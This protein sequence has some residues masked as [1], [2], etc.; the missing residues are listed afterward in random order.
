MVRLVGLGLTKGR[1]GR[2]STGKHAASGEYSPYDDWEIQ[3]VG[4]IQQNL[5]VGL[6]TQVLQPLCE[7]F[8][9]HFGLLNAEIATG[10]CRIKKQWALSSFRVTRGK[11]V[12]WDIDRGKLQIYGE[13]GINHASSSGNIGFLHRDSVK[14]EQSS[15]LVSA[16][17]DPAT[18]GPEHCITWRDVQYDAYN[19]AHHTHVVPQRTL[20]M[21]WSSAPSTP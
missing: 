3:L 14:R 17:I 6:E 20:G 15:G 2:R 4:R 18:V 21:T 19:I 13:G 12:G 1:G 16:K 11:H 10:V 8:N 5:I 9:D 7:P